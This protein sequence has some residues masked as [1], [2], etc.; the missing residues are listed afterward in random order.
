MLRRLPLVLVAVFVGML[1]TS[2]PV[3][4]QQTVVAQEAEGD[5][6]PAGDGL[7]FVVRTGATAS[8]LR[9]QLDVSGP[10]RVEFDVG[11][12]FAAMAGID[13]PL[14]ERVSVQAEVGVVRR[15][16][17]LDLAGDVVRSKL[18]VNYV[19]VP[20][21]LK[22]YPAGKSGSRLHLDAGA[23]PAFRLAASREVRQGDAI[24]D[25]PSEGLLTDNDLSVAVGLGLELSE[26]FAHFT[27]DVRYLHGLSE[28]NAAPGQRAARW[29][30]L[31]ALVGVIF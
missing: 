14:A 21:L 11:Y 29:S 4:A 20:L 7:R 10:G 25:V 1:W 2:P 23:V 3:R 8:V 19:E 13:V 5:G 18:S 31:Q 24:L 30:S 12:G 26:L 15:L 6:E 27:V 17:R 22:W 9:G 28:A 16:T